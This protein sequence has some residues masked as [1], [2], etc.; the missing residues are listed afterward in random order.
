MKTNSIIAL[1]G[2]VLHALILAEGKYI[3]MEIEKTEGKN[4]PIYLE[5][6]S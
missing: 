3:L 4:I 5:Y 6:L 2:V 1:I